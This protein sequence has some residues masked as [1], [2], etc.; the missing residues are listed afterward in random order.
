M[1]PFEYVAPG[2]VEEA[3]AAIG[4]LPG[5]G[6]FI[7]GGTNLL[8]LMKER[9]MKPPLL[10]DLNALPLADITAEPN[11]GLRLG[12]LATNADTAHHPLV[13]KGYPLLRAAILAGASPQI[14]N[15]A[16]NGGNLLQR[17]RCVYFYDAGV[18]CNKHTP[19]SGCP[20]A[21][22]LARQ[23]AILGASPHCIATHPSDMCV[24]LA[25]LEAVVQ[26]RSARGAREIPFAEFH[27]LPGDQ[28][29]IDTTLASDEL[30]TH[31]VLPDARRYAARS[32]YL[33]LRERASY[34][35]AL[36]SVAAALELSEDGRVQ[37][38]RIALGGVAHKPWRDPAAEA[39]LVGRPAT[40]ATF[41]LAA[42]VLL[43]EARPWGGPGLPDGP[44]GNSFKIPLARRAIVRALEMAAAG[45]ISNTGEDGARLQ[46]ERDGSRRLEVTR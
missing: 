36:V 4:T 5:Q 35:F 16:T 1:H 23:H 18:P 28:P 9:V 37:S 14:R 6:R 46:G 32:C 19:G 24:A 30:I 29:E 2:S 26:V 20:A 21:T 17:T 11:G 25:A 22:G 44:P 31:L 40:A 39:L 13:R 41:S 7:A 33:K 34:A 45:E 15:M 8:D 43:A 38:A 42:D 12:A 10:V 27:R 3:L